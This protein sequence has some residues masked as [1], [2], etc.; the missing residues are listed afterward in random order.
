MLVTRLAAGFLV[1]LFGGA[2]GERSRLPLDRALGGFEA[3]LEVGH[4]PLELVN[5]PVALLQ[6]L[7]QLFVLRL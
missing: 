5:E 3:L 2:A 6:L 7:P 4:G 1:V